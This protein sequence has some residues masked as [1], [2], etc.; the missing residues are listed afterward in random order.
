MHLEREIKLADSKGGTKSATISGDARY[1][2]EGGFSRRECQLTLC[3]DDTK[4]HGTGTDFFDAFCSI[5]KQLATSGIFP[6]C[7][8]ASRN[9]YPSGMTRDMGDG[10][11]AY[12]LYV[13]KSARLEDIVDIFD[14]GEDVEVAT[15]EAQQAF[16]DAWLNRYIKRAGTAGA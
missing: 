9:V 3:Y 16:A 2:S 11:Q 6:V 5:R 15:V 8:G 10:L 4:L 12:R 13:G 1:W 14:T 7:Y